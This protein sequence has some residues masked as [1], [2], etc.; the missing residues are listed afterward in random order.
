MLAK[1]LSLKALFTWSNNEMW[2]VKLPLVDFQIYWKR[3]G[4]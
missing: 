1:E 4:S 3:V 2:N